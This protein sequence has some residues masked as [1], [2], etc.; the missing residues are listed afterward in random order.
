VNEA[1]RLLA[2]GHNRDRATYELRV[3]AAL[4]D[5]VEK[6]IDTHV[7]LARATSAATWRDIGESLGM[8]PQSAHEKFNGRT[9]R[10]Q[11]R[12]SESPDSGR[13]DQTPGDTRPATDAPSGPADDQ[14]D[15]EGRQGPIRRDD[16][17]DSLD[18]PTRDEMEAAW[19]RLAD[20]GALDHLLPKKRRYRRPRF[21]GMAVVDDSG[22]YEVARRL[23]V[24]TSRVE[25]AFADLGYSVGWDYATPITEAAILSVVANLRTESEDTR[26]DHRF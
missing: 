8:S 22:V 25:S 1:T 9:R 12:G 24:S 4:R 3:L 13:R 17:A 14:R 19:R 23:G 6:Q 5:A 2:E 18:E 15:A 11:P 16:A 20:E 7:L 21:G 26:R 10:S